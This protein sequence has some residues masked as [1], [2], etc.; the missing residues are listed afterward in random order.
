M[1]TIKYNGIIYTLPIVV[2]RIDYQR[3]PSVIVTI[4]F[5]NDYP[6]ESRL[7]TYSHIGTVAVFWKKETK[8][9]YVDSFY[10]YPLIDPACATKE[11]LDS[12]RGV[13]KHILCLGITE[14]ADMFKEDVTMDT[15]VYLDASS[16]RGCIKKVDDAYIPYSESEIEKY[17]KDKIPS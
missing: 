1:Y 10:L 12:L 14:M 3:L 8:R 4:N 2:R 11:E 6:K 15:I 9:M 17:F 16:L 5:P 13:G 7:R